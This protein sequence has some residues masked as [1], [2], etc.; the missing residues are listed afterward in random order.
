MPNIETAEALAAKPTL[1]EPS[2]TL[3]ERLSV[4]EERDLARCAQ[5]IRE[6]GIV[7][8]PFNGVFGL[9][10]DIDNLPAAEA[11]IAVKKRPKERKLL[12]VSTPESI[13][14]YTD[15]SRTNYSRE[16][17]IALWKDIH[18]LGIILPASTHAPYHLT[19]GEDMIDRTILTIWTEYTPLRT[20]IE[21]CY[22]MGGR[23]LVGTSANKFGEAT[24]FDPDSIWEDFKTDLRA[25]VVDRFDELPP[26]RKKSTSIIDLTNDHPRLHREG[27]V[28][29]VEIRAA[30]K[31]HNFP[32]LVIGRDVIVVRGRDENSTLRR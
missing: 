26:N 24:H 2:T 16:S 18:A 22:R 25:V 27:N 12:A 6:G 11:I 13:E 9:F 4:V 29:E 28:S 20:M 15:L 23:G 5:V 30:L 17:L 1:P 14:A 3:A 19:V 32:E 21:H 10:G 31:R 8:F 7:A